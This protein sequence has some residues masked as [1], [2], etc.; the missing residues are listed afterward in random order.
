MNNNLSLVFK[1]LRKRGFLARQNFKCCGNCAGYALT[2]EAVVKVGAG[3]TVRGSVFYHRQ[4]RQH[5]E[6]S[7]KLMIRYGSLD[8]NELGV[9]GE[10]TT[11]IGQEV[12]AVFETHGI[13]VQ[14]NGDSSQCIEVFPNEHRA[15]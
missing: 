15:Q 7:G 9:I 3:K 13:K 4:D 2:N 6:H 11:K 10:D 5:F 14:W 12:V 1:E 8:S